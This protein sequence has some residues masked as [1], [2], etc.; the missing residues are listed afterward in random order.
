MSDRYCTA[1]ELGLR[2]CQALQLDVADVARLV[3]DLRPHDVATIQVTMY[4]R[5]VVADEIVTALR[6]YTIE[7]KVQP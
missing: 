3:L 6:S 1:N 5:E 2:I 7:P 4:V